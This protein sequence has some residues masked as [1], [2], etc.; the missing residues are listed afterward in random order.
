MKFQLLPLL[1]EYS[2]I[3]GDL[4]VV[5]ST[6]LPVEVVSD[7]VILVFPPVGG[8]IAGV[9]SVVIDGVSGYLTEYTRTYEEEEAKSW[10]KKWGETGPVSFA[11]FGRPPG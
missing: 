3:T 11:S 9:S 4:L 1:E 6:G 8:T 2:R 5:V 7:P 10:T